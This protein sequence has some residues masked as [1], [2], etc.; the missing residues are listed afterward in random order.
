MS[1][2]ASFDSRRACAGSRNSGR[3]GTVVGQAAR[4]AL[5][6]LDRDRKILTNLSSLLIWAEA[7]LNLSEPIQLIRTISDKN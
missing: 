4:A 7:Q 3:W 6:Q 5:L 2:Q 1:W